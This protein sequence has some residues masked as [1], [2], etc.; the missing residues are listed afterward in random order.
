MRD[1][2]ESHDFQKERTDLPQRDADALA[3][4]SASVCNGLR[5]WDPEEPD[6]ERPR[7]YF[8]RLFGADRTTQILVIERIAWE[9]ETSHYPI[10]ELRNLAQKLFHD[11]NTPEIADKVSVEIQPVPS[12]IGIKRQISMMFHHLIDNALKVSGHLQRAAIQLFSGSGAREGQ[13][14]IKVCN[15]KKG[16]QPNCRDRIF[17]MFYRLQTKSDYPGLRLVL[18]INE[19]HAATRGGSTSNL[20]LGR[21]P[22]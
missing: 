20:C 18:A 17:E 5:Y 3:F 10:C 7:P 8:W 16:I 22:R 9:A 6:D 13:V 15:N 1:A 4:L 14:A 11:M 19:L 12:V 21:R 2:A